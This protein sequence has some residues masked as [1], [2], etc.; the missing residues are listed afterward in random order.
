M[1][2]ENIAST[3]RDAMRPHCIA[4]AQHTVGSAR[5]CRH[6]SRGQVPRANVAGAAA[7]AV[8]CGRACAARVLPRVR[9]GI[10]GAPA[11]PV[12]AGKLS[13]PAVAVPS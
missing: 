1:V 9:R 6:P 11:R 3:L 5:P 10:R 13:A 8:H 12:D 4:K 2:C 7:V